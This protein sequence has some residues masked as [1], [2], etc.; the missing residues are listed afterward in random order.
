MNGMCDK[1]LVPDTIFSTG[2]EEGLHDF[3]PKHVCIEYYLI[4][5]F[6]E[7]ANNFL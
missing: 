1:G 7:T 4:L 5:K 3:P 2:I 6:K